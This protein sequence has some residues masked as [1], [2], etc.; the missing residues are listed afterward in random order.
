[1]AQNNNVAAGEVAGAVAGGRQQNPAVE[2][3]KASWRRT[4]MGGITYPVVLR[5]EGGRLRVLT[6]IWEEYSKTHSHGVW[7]YPKAD[8]DMLIYLEQSNSGK[9]SAYVSMCRLTPQQCKAVE[10]AAR[11]M[12]GVAATTRQVEK[13]L[14]VLELA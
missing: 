6:P 10:E 9:R 1:M 5:V 13:M 7:Y 2:V 11:A 3:I 8:V 12:W 4:R 14:E